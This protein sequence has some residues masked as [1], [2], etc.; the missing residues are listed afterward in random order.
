M[1]TKEESLTSFL[2]GVV[3]KGYPYAGSGRIDLSVEPLRGYVRLREDGVIEFEAI[4]ERL[5]SSGDDFLLGKAPTALALSTPVGGAILVDVHPRVGGAFN[6]G[7]DQE[8]VVRVR[9]SSVLFGVDLSGI[10]S[11]KLHDVSV[12][13]DGLGSWAGLKTMSTAVKS[14]AGG[15][16]EEATISLK[17]HA[18]LT[19]RKMVPGSQK[20]S[21]DGDWETKEGPDGGMSIRTSLRVRL[22]ALRPRASSDYLTAILDIQ[23]LFSLVYRGWVPARPGPASLASYAGSSPLFWTRSAMHRSPHAIVMP[24]RPRAIFG[25]KHLGGVDGISRW[26]HLCTNFRSAV[27][28]VTSPYREGPEG[29]EASVQRLGAAI[30]RYVGTHRRT[31]TWAAKAT[32]ATP[33]L[34]L[35]RRAGGPAFK[36]WVG[37]PSRWA[38]EFHKQY[39]ASKHHTPTSV[40]PAVAAWLARSGRWL[41]VAALLDRMALTKVPSKG[42]FGPGELSGLGAEVRRVLGT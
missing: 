28:A 1:A 20:L 39:V 29:I 23:D 3:A 6:F 33:E 7:G 42:I 34:A 8:S 25:S 5:L 24:E 30:E 31:T 16:A 32:A 21:L 26:T 37:D 35:A 12:R 38:A 15:V 10:R 18:T 2:A 27:S 13:Y 36:V 19:A 22:S 40:D 4:D 41:L 17:S 11:L 9:A 14:G